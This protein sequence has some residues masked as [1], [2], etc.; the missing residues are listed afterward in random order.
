M[1]EWARIVLFK[2][3]QFDLEIAS[4]ALRSASTQDEME[5][6]KDVDESLKVVLTIVVFHRQTFSDEDR[7]FN[8]SW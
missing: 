7:S 1:F 2:Y 6:R 8:V 4:R 5:T 3:A